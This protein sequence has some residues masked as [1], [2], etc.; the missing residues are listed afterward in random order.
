MT[1]V[2]TNIADAATAYL[3]AG[4]SVLP[5]RRVEKYAALPQWKQYQERLP[6][7][8]EIEAWFSNGHDGLCLVTGVVSGNLE[9]IDFD[10]AAELYEPWRQRVEAASPGM[11]DRLAVETT[12]SGGKHVAYRCSDPVCGNMKLAQRQIDTPSNEPVTIHGKTLTPRRDPATG[13]WY[14]VVTLIETRGEGGLF[15]CAPTAGYEMT[16]G[17]LASL[18]VLTAV[19][20]DVLLEAAWALNEYVP[21]PEQ[22]R[23]AETPSALSGGGGALRPGDDYNERGDPRCVLI[24]HG[25]TLDRCGS[26]SEYWR[27]PGK[28]SG[29]SASFPGRGRVFYVFS[30]NAA[31]FEPEKSYLPFA[32][33]ALLEHDGD[34]AKAAAAL[35]ADGYGTPTCTGGVDLSGIMSGNGAAVAPTPTPKP[36]PGVE[37]PGPFPAELLE[38]PGFVGEVMQYTLRTAPYPQPVLA[39]GGALSLQ[40]FLAGRKVRDTADARTNLYVLA[41]ANSG[42]GKDHPRKVNQK[43]L[44]AAG[45]QDG[46][47]DKFASGEG[48]EDRLFTQPS[49]L[50]QTDEIDGLMQAINQARD[51]RHESILNTLL[52]MYSSASA[53]YPMRV[54]AGKESPG[55]IDQP[56]LCMLGTAVPKY[57]YEA[58]SMRMLNN[59]FFA[60]MLILEA[61]KRG[62]GQDPVLEDLP[63]QVVEIARWWAAFTPGSDNPGGRANLAA[64]HP[65]PKVVLQ[66]AEAGDILRHLREESDG[67]YAQA[68]ERDDQTAMAIWARAYEKVR[69]LALIYAVSQSHANPWISAK[70]AQWASA[71]VDYQTRRMLY[72]AAQHVAEGEFDSKCK[73]LVEVLTAWHS[74]KGQVWMPHWELARRLK[75]SDKDIDEVRDALLNQV[76]IDFEG[77][78]TPRGG[79]TGFRYQLIKAAEE[80]AKDAR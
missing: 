19:E 60:R 73:R 40:A 34:Y 30:S 53:L 42:A 46:L 64:W 72:M 45:L 3:G 63:D 4:L 51:S 57:F 24:K 36:L 48:I 62:T 13:T 5:A 6:T 22:P 68:E 50:F 10:F 11:L 8:I 56:S 35:R 74:R 32:V 78:S 27:R 75:W 77:G 20:R 1:A 23:T 52:K 29:W 17:D 14:V 49:M 2:T 47:G 38:V 66:T 43:V 18:P 70:A 69:K 71:L 79:R 7:P 26:E 25:W 9:I 58:L 21:P 12:P 37:D 55:V 59:G 41:L 16:H 80:G 54:K 76:V 44:L 39:F 61:G 65:Q 33:Y 31:P 67:R 28:T 15:L